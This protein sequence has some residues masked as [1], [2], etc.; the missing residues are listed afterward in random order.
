MPGFQAK[1]YADIMS[2]YPDANPVD[3]A[4]LLGQAFNFGDLALG[5]GQVEDIQ[6]AIDKVKKFLEGTLGSRSVE[7]GETGTVL[8]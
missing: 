7:G 4:M 3:V 2:E 1:A 6:A 5:I 8:E